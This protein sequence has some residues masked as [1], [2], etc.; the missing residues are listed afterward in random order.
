VIGFR[1]VGTASKSKPTD[2]ETSA[3]FA[4]ERVTQ[5]LVKLYIVPLHRRLRHMRLEWRSVSSRQAGV[6]AKNLHGYS[7]TRASSLTQNHF[8][9]IDRNGWSMHGWLCH[10]CWGLD[11]VHLVDGVP[12]CQRCEATCTHCCPVKLVSVSEKPNVCKASRDYFLV[13]I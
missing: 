6:G 9:T 1:L 11:L 10:N 2:P 7:S 5:T 13:S 8:L 3:A 12:R 4:S